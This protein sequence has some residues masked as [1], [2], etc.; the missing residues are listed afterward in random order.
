LGV[1]GCSWSVGVFV[2]VGVAGRVI[3]DGVGY[4]TVRQALTMTANRDSCFERVYAGVAT[5]IPIRW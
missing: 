5:P 4:C 1:V 2:V 3:V